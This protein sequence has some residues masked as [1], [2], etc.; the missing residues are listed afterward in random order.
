[1]SVRWAYLSG[2]C[3]AVG[4]RDWS[5]RALF[6]AEWFPR[7]GAKQHPA[8]PVAH[9]LRA[10]MGNA[11]GC[12]DG[13]SPYHCHIPIKHCRVRSSMWRTGRGRL[14]AG[15]ARFPAGHLPHARPRA[16]R[17]PGRGFP[18]RF[19][20]ISAGFPPGP[21]RVPAGF[22]PGPRQVPPAWPSRFPT[23]FPCV[24]SQVSARFLPVP[25]RYKSLGGLA[26]PTPT[27]PYSYE[28]AAKAP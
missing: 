26:K 3:P 24:A 12:G 13:A 8:R 10:S 28:I 19:P 11:Q 18:A 27:S 21:R 16:G 25:V 6:G 9:E 7:R 1:M 4:N 14:G 23:G 2:G 15:G 5:R 22:P 17:K 20:R